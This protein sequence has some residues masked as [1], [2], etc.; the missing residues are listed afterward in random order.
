MRKVLEVYL[1]L[2][3]NKETIN[4]TNVMLFMYKYDNFVDFMHHE[5]ITRFCLVAFIFGKYTCMNIGT[6]PPFHVY[7]VHK[8]TS[9]LAVIGFMIL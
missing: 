7:F 1:Y 8:F 6:L 4:D 2:K 5:S 3:K 9:F